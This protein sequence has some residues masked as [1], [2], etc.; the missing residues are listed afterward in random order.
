MKSFLMFF[1][2]VLCIYSIG[3]AYLFVRGWQALEIAGRQRIWF[4]ILFW[5]IA[6]LFVITQILRVKGA[7]GTVF[8]FLFTIGSFW[9]AI[10]LYGFL[11]LITIDI[12]RIIGWAGNIKPDFIYHNYQIS[13]VVIFGIFCLVS[14]VIIGMGYSNAY[15]QQITH[16]E[17]PID[18]KAGQ[19]SG[20]R[21]VMVSDIHL[22]H[23]NGNKMLTRVVEKINEQNPDLVLLAG[24]TFD[25]APDPVIKKNTGALFDQL[26]TKYGVYAISG[27]HEYIGNRENSEAVEKAFGYLA[28]HKIQPLQDSVVLID[29]SFYLAGRNDRMAATRKA[30][31]ELLHGIDHQL[32]IIMLDHQ[33]F[34]FDKVEQAGVDLQLSGHTHHGQMWPL[35]YITRKIYEQDWGF[36]KKGKSNFYISCGVGTWGP[37]IRTAGFSEIVVIDLNFK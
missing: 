9:L 28:S 23:I 36:L 5:V 33:P 3:N 2:I 15:R 18:K 16:L 27:N 8:D 19:L 10:M 24:D 35:N 13:K 7:S 29:N 20:L 11:I 12:L 31:P 21:L 34:Q 6:S 17:I 25:G 4:A 32:P 22:G 14:A 37:P 1:I 26:Q 30:I